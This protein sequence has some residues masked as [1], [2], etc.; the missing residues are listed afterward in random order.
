ML[1]FEER[2]LLSGTVLGVLHCGTHWLVVCCNFDGDVGTVSSFGFCASTAS[3]L[4]R[5]FFF[6]LEMVWR[7]DALFRDAFELEGV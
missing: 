6:V 7:G 1:V 2:L 5:R 4:L 3:T